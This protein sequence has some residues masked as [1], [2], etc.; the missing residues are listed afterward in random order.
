M[1]EQTCTCGGQEHAINCP[2]RPAVTV[3]V[4]STVVAVDGWP[5][6][7][8]AAVPVWPWYAHVDDYS[9]E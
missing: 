1:P 8:R 5:Y 7:S 3:T 9:S 6:V 4:V 2:L